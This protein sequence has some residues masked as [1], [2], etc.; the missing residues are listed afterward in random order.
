MELANFHKLQ[1]AEK[2]SK[3]EHDFRK[4]QIAATRAQALLDQ[5]EKHFYNY[6]EKVIDTYKQKGGNIKPL[7]LEVKG[8]SAATLQF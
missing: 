4:E 5:Q 2:V 6:A 1:N 8:Q 7:L 3:V